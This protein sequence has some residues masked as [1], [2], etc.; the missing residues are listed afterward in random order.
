M[1]V[2]LIHAVCGVELFTRGDAIV[3]AWHFTAAFC[4][5][6]NIQFTE[7]LKALA[8]EWGCTT[9]QLALAWLHAQVCTLLTARDPNANLENHTEVECILCQKSCTTHI[10]A[11]ETCTAGSLSSSDDR[12]AMKP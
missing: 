3:A 2:L 12:A 1:Y 10:E 4:L 6:Q 11:A 8:D 5:L 9:C 7:N